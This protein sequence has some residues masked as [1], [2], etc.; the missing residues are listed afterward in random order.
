MIQ[1]SGEKEDIANPESPH[2]N[3]VKAMIGQTMINYSYFAV[4][5][6][7]FRDILYTDV[8]RS[9][10]NLM[11]TPVKGV[12]LSFTGQMVKFIYRSSKNI[13]AYYQ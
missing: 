8:N 3:S 11:T 6:E 12:T 1:K 2:A 10:L 4:N 9:N 7:R 5:T 13:I